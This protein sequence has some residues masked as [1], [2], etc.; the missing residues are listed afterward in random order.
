MNKLLKQTNS[1]T[2]R[3][4]IFFS[5]KRIIMIIAFIS[6][7]VS[8]VHAGDIVVEHPSFGVSNHFDSIEIEKIVLNDTATVLYCK[9]FNQPGYRISITR[10]YLQANG[11]KYPVQHAVDIEFDKEACANQ[12]GEIA[13]SMIFPPI[14]ANTQYFD[15]IEEDNPQDKGWIWDIAFQAKKAKSY[16]KLPEEFRKAAHPKDDGT[17]LTPPAW[18]EAN[19]VLKGRIAGYRP[20]MKY[21]LNIYFPSI[22]TESLE[23]HS[24]NVNDDGSFEISVPM[25][26]ATQVWLKFGYKVFNGNRVRTNGK[27]LLTP[28]DTAQLYV[29][30]P[31][32]FKSVSR[33]RKDRT[34]VPVF[35][36]HKR[37][38]QQSDF[39]YKQSKIS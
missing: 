16:G 20:E 37:G 24:A 14:D 19:A 33:L 21:D 31:A 12:Q 6:W 22:I 30:L 1:S 7:A 4:N 15:L 27:V 25:L 13:F 34:K 26:V 3:K 11:K 28:G 5:M 17:A 35:F 18:L 29:D 8:T 36:R 23:N 38:Y 32:C 9:G 39:R 10:C 2:G